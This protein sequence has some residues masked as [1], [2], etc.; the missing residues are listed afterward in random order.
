MRS[1]SAAFAMPRPLTSNNISGK[2]FFIV[3]MR[4]TAPLYLV[5]ILS[6]GF[7]FRRDTVFRCARTELRRHAYAWNPRE[8]FTKKHQ[9][10]AAAFPRRDSMLLQQI[11]QRSGGPVFARLHA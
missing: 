7:P 3:V 2:N 10:H 6:A 9:W 1:G 11:L 4:G 8:L 5:L